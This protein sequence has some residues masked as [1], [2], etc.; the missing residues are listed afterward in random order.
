MVNPELKSNQ[1]F[2]RGKHGGKSGP[3]PCVKRLGWSRAFT[4]NVVWILA[5]FHG[6]SSP[7]PGSH[8]VSGS[9]LQLQL[10]GTQAQEA[11]AQERTG[12]T[13]H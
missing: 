5:K 3:E 6:A 4:K 7:S 11:P 8:R 13:G 1:E 2:G 12:R 10:V 9:L